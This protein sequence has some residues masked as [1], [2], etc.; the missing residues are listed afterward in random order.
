MLGRLRD[1]VRRGGA[2]PAAA[3]LAERHG[4]TTWRL[5]ALQ[6]LALTEAT[7]RRETHVREVRRV[8]A[9]AGAHITVAQ[10]DLVLADMALD[11]LR[12]RRLPGGGGALRRRQPALRAREPPRRAALAG[13]GARTRRA[14]TEMEAVLAEAAAAAPGDARV[15]ADAWGRVRATYHALRE[16]R[17]ALRARTRPVDGV[18]ARRAG[19]GVGLPGTDTV[20]AAAA[21]CPTTTSGS[22]A[23]A[24][25]AES[26]LVRAGFGDAALA[27]VDAVVLGRQGRGRTRRPPRCE[28]PARGRRT[29]L[30]VVRPAADRRGRGP[31][32]LGRAGRL[33]A[34]DR[35]VLRRT[36]ATTGSPGSAGPCSSPPVRRPSAADAAGR[37]SRRPCAGSGITSREL[38]VLALVA[39]A[40]PTREIA[41]RLFLSPRTVEHHVASL[42]A[43]TG[44]APAPSSPP[45]AAQTG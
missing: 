39:D 25:I 42:L 34:R 41:A 10:M 17:A 4:L 21:R 37:P 28:R 32:R 23:R 38:D 12:P 15:E 40:L 35:G 26:R 16:D 20:G 36:A 9:D 24:E 18:H 43:R 19:D 1:G 2:V 13:R 22:A 7:T 5:R 30:V 14:G 6:E 27:L 11:T 44:S 3:D 8:A 45:S 31:R 33:A 29:R